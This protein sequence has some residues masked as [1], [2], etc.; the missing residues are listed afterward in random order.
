[1][2]YQ[3]TNAGTMHIYKTTMDHSNTVDLCNIREIVQVL[4]RSCTLIVHAYVTFS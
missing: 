3:I 1:M 2:E 4:D